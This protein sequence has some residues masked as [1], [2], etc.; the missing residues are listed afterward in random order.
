MT[1]RAQLAAAVDVAAVVLFVAIGRRSHDETGNAVTGALK[2]AAPFLIAL[3]VAWAAAKAWSNPIS[4]RTGVVLWL[5]TVTVGLVLRK[6]IFDGGTATAF[7]IV[8][9]I[10]LGAMLL[11][12]RA[13]W[14]WRTAT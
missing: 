4:M 6:V 1:R 8:A 14:R 13:I 9:T 3:L 12:W 5:G 11:G 7:V 2:V 10:T